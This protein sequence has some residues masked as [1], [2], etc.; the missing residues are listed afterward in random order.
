M[1]GK[2]NYYFFISILAIII[3]LVLC[4][5]FF[6]IA[7]V[8]SSSLGYFPNVSNDLNIIFFK[9]IF[10][11]PGIKKSIYLT[12]IVGFVSTL[13]SLI[14]SQIIL[15]KLYD[16]KFYKYIFKIIAPLIAFPHVIMAVGLSYLFSS[17]GIV[18]RLYH[19]YILDYNRPQNTNLFPDDFGIFLILGLI[20]KETP[21]FLLMSIN[22]LSQFPGRDF[23]NIGR[24]FHDIKINSWLFFIFPQ[25]YVR[26]RVCIIIVIIYSA[27]VI[28]MAFILAPSTPSTISIRIIDLFQT[29]DLN[30]LAIASCL[31]IFQFLLILFIIILWF[32]IEYFCKQRYLY[33]HYLKIFPILNKFF[34]KLLYLVSIKLLLISFLCIFLS[35]LWSISK[36]W[37][38]PDLIP[39]E[40][41]TENYL[42]FFQYFY[43]SLFNTIFIAMIVSLLSCGLILIWLEVTE[44]INFKSQIFEFIFFIPILIP[45][46]SFLLGINALFIQN[47]LS[48]NIW[49]L[50][51]V[52]SLYVIPYSYLILMPAYRG[53]NK[54]FINNAKMFQKSNLNIFFYIKIT[55]IIKAIFLALGIGFIISIALYAPVYFIGDNQISTLSIEIVNL[56]FSANRKDLGVSTVLQMTLPLIML[57]IIFLSNKF[58]V[59]WRY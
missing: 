33:D 11:I 23:A 5:V 24:T 50:I 54:N 14:L 49:G 34:E 3:F 22:A 12:F 21:F 4:P 32:L 25:V 17:S 13:I 37:H 52:E 42:H 44:Q 29:P 38:F 26:L 10:E 40:F 48:G 45:E 39:S 35:F 41:T 28:D 7:S 20:L 36:T 16:T 56:S 18:F 51:W 46:L 1:I 59:K 53:I 31:S 15:S 58:F 27:S 6:G 9:K 55:L 30:N 57:L 19:S 47:N 43:N 2:I 8:I